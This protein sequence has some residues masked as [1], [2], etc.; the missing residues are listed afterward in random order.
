MTSRRVRTPRPAVPMTLPRLVVLTDRSQL[1]LGRGLATTIR[2]CVDAGL[3]AVV[4]REH[5]LAPRA[6]SALLGELTT[7]PGLLVV[8]SRIPDPRAHGL[9]LSA[10]QASPGWAGPGGGRAARRPLESRSC[11]GREAVAR[12]A[13]Q[14]AAWA[15]LSP[16]AASLSKPGRP[17]LSPDSWADHPIPVLALAG[18]DPDNA[19]AA[20]EAGAHGV[21]VMGAVM[22]A[23]EPAA[24]VERLVE[25]VA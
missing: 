1:R 7:I 9:H 13:A 21:A 20:I 24:M 15:T 14:G 22:R 12:A 11:H 16:Y 2:E 6:R 4:V 5:D 17:P 3:E 23:A 25:V 8:S 18:V 10:S 19:R